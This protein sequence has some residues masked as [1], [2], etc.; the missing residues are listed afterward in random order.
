VHIP[1]KEYTMSKFKYLPE[2][3]YYQRLISL[4][5]PKA[6]AQGM[7]SEVSMWTMKSGPEW[8]VKRLKALK[9]DFIQILA[10]N[11]RVSTWIKYKANA[12]AGAF[13]RLFRYGL[14]NH[15]DSKTLFRVLNALNGH[16]SFLS[17]V[18]TDAQLNK[19][20]SSVSA[21]PVVESVI[22]NVFGFI[23]PVAR[24]LSVNPK[25]QIRTLKD[26]KPN[27]SKRAPS[28]DGPSV[29]EKRWLDTI[30]CIWETK[31]GSNLWYNFTQL[32]T[33]LNPVSTIIEGHLKMPPSWFKA[34][35]EVQSQGFAGKIGHIQE[36]GLK[37]RAVANP[38]RVYQLA[39]SR[40]GDQLYRLVEQLPWDC[41][42]D[43]DSGCEWSKRKLYEGHT[44][45]AVDLSDATN[46]FPLALQIRLLHCIKHVNLEDIHLLEALA[47]APWLSPTQGLVTWTKGQPLGLYPSFAIFTLTH[48]M[49]LRGIEHSLGISDSFRV[50][51]DDVVISDARVHTL[52]RNVLADLG[53]PVSEEKTLIS[54]QITEFGGRI[55]SPTSTI[56]L[57]KWRTVSD[58]NF[59]DLLKNI[60]ARFLT[61][62]L[63]RQ[64]RV[65]EMIMTLPE[66]VGLGMNP[67]GLTAE[68]RWE[69]E[70]KLSY[71]FEPKYELPEFREQNWPWCLI[72]TNIFKAILFDGLIAE[73][74]WQVAN[75]PKG[76][77]TSASWSLFLDLHSN[78]KR[79]TGVSTL[80]SSQVAQ[81]SLSYPDMLELTR[82]LAGV[83][84]LIH[85]FTTGDPRGESALKYWEKAISAGKIQKH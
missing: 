59:M 85:A 23:E 30:S 29:P 13:G 36:P 26:Y 32:R 48:G 84:A 33:V 54:D 67:K 72:E 37:L 64:R 75:P 27:P 81:L 3:D 28:A 49:L 8:T 52:Y 74:D 4:Y 38:F 73:G 9:T 42:H 5:I 22:D 20:Y 43:Q 77:S 58:R 46:M 16:T 55:I 45:F 15:T 11:G 44:M 61:C 57:G 53:M 12:P 41:T 82:K 24:K 47:T 31:L 69:L 14:K 6:I 21:E 18:E 63:P 60:G 80:P 66:P 65:A 1:K 83:L 35:R 70:D 51:G 62:L 78:L 50:L 25:T 7:A 76:A 17:L 10:G 79:I 68:A 39:L 2:K 56:S 71:L 19:F 34:G 40:L